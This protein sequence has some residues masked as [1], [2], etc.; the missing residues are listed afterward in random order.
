MSQRK[1]YHIACPQC[2]QQQ[3]VHLYDAINATR[4]PAL[5]DALME[6]RL[7]A[8]A[9]R[10]CAFSFRVDKPLLYHDPGRRLMIYWI[11]AGDDQHEQ[12][13]EAFRESVS[14]ITA[15]MPSDV[16]LPEIHLVF[17]RTELVERIF[18]REAG[19]NE[20]IIEYIKYMIYVQNVD[21]VSPADKVLLFNAEDS[22]EQSLC[23]VVQDVASRKLESV[24]EYKRS[25]YTALCEMFDHDE[26]TPTLLELF[27]G[28]HINARSLLL[29]ESQVDGS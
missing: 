1:T 18:L 6:N 10:A 15:L 9:C 19:L 24:F 17:N 12:G 4:E 8:V 27:P 22:R 14:S 3:D 23:F 5:R 7:N 26:R 21:R 28:P 16:P 29:K 25:A 11:P 20:R 13:E 2:G